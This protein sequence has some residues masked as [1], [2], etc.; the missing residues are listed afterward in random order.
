MTPKEYVLSI[1]EDAV[2][3][4]ID[5]LFYIDRRNDGHGY[6]PSQ[7]SSP[8]AT[9]MQA[10]KGIEKEESIKKKKKEYRC[11]R[12]DRNDNLTRFDY[13]HGLAFKCRFCDVFF[14]IY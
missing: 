3:I 11:P 1:Y 2:V 4:E 6:V 13:N 14:R 8:G 5:D 12:C 10:M 7:S 9:W